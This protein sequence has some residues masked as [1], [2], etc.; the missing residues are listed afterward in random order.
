MQ[1]WFY[2]FVIT[3]TTLHPAPC[4]A[5]N[6][7][8]LSWRKMKCERRQS[9]AE[10]IHTLNWGR[11]KTNTRESGATMAA[12]AET[13][14]FF[15]TRRTIRLSFSM[16]CV[17]ACVCV[18][19]RQQKCCFF[20]FHRIELCPCQNWDFRWIVYHV[21]SSCSFVQGVEL[22]FLGDSLNMTENF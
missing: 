2:W 4:S 12:T 6:G 21:K 16:I 15:P 22:R 5:G 11:P 7:C 13:A 1:I 9:G 14:S 10:R 18:V 17:R 19:R 20:W 8:W 3:R